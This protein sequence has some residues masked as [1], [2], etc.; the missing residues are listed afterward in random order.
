MKTIVD[1]QSCE[2]NNYVKQPRVFC[3]YNLLI[4]IKAKSNRQSYFSQDIKKEIFVLIF[5][6]KFTFMHSNILS[7]KQRPI[8]YFQ[9]K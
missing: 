8:S 7:G 5:T 9:D 6:L 2:Q 1:L 4:N 3:S